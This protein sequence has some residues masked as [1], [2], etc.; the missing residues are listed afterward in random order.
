MSADDQ[1]RVS[2]D[3]TSEG[4]AKAGTLHSVGGRRG[5]GTFGRAL[6][7]LFTPLLI[8]SLIA[9]FSLFGLY[10]SF[11]IPV[12]WAGRSVSFRKSTC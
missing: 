11:S 12:A 7:W 3:S 4:P 1:T 8:A 10:S 6:R 9:N 2:G 5:G